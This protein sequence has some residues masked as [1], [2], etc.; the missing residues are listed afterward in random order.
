[1]LLQNPN[2]PSPS[3]NNPF[4]ENHGVDAMVNEERS[5]IV[6]CERIM[7]KLENISSFSKNTLLIRDELNGSKCCGEMWIRDF[8]E[9]VSSKLDTIRELKKSWMN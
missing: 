8:A 5:C 7:E 2:V 1:L 9:R 6:D 3:G 4:E